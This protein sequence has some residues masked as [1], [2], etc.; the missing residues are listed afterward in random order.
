ML[1]T[2]HCL[3]H[4]VADSSTVNLL[5]LQTPAASLVLG[6]KGR[7]CQIQVHSSPQS[8]QKKERPVNAGMPEWY[9]V[10]ITLI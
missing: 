10:A 3:G 6:F 4:G 9:S 5:V 1:M 7:N 8:T 2:L